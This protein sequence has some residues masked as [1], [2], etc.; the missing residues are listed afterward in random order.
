MRFLRRLVVR[1]AQELAANPEARA[2]ASQVLEE[3]IKP[4]AKKAWQQAQPEIE[5]AKQGVKSYAKKLRD[6]YRK[7][8][9]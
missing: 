4:R 1:A 7:G 9:G 5:N 2:K 8:R 6:E 3:N